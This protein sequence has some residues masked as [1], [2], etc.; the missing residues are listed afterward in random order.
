VNKID[1]IESRLGRIEKLLQD[2]SIERRSGL[3]LATPAP[4]NTSSDNA[5]LKGSSSLIITPEKSPKNVED[6]VPSREG[7]PSFEGGTALSAHTTFASEYFES[8]L[9]NSHLV[10]Q[11]PDLASTL[12]SLRRMVLEHGD[13]PRHHESHFCTSKCPKRY[14]VRLELPPAE[15][16]SAMLHDVKDMFLAWMGVMGPFPEPARL[17]EL[18]KSLYFSPDD[19][20]HAQLILT[21]G[22]LYWCFDMY[23]VCKPES[24]NIEKFLTYSELCK[25]GV[26]SLL[27]G[28][29]LNMPVNMESAQALL[30]GV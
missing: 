27:E 6:T 23:P 14:P 18:V 24:P 5:S 13:A 15:A 19:M 4:T 1:A 8:A 26:E 30:T 25:Q 2:L 7:S 12:S 21:V 17:T 28:L 29:D 11:D 20:T 16:V 10:D 3:S 22:C 9:N